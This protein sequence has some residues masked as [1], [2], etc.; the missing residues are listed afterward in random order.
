MRSWD[1]I[2]SIDVGQ[3]HDF[4]A[5]CVLTPLVWC[6]PEPP[7]PTGLYG[8][9]VDPLAGVAERHG[10]G[11]LSPLALPADDLAALRRTNRPAPSRPPLHVVHLDRVRGEPYP[12]VV[13][14]VVRLV[15]KIPGHL[16]TRVVADV[17]GVG[18]GVG[19]L[20]R[21]RGVDAW[22]V[23]A[24]AGDRVSRAWPDIGC[25]KRELI[26]TTQVLLSN[27]RLRISPELALAQTL[28]D[29]L[30]SYEVRITPGGHDTY[31]PRSGAYDDLL[32]SLCQACWSFEHYW[33][34][35]LADDDEA[36]RSP[37]HSG[38]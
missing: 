25:P 1:A 20:M 22:F 33:G 19:D 35:V 14:R 31:E 15:A 2:V 30:L 38:G 7:R 10:A 36:R 23:T 3:R 11:W 34:N 32:Y 13:D 17:G 8:L 4:T 16:E 24:T 21:A 27:G 18:R 37:A 9:S 6:R 28:V 29:E 12:S 5:V 26:T